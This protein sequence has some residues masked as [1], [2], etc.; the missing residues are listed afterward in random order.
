LHSERLLLRPFV[1]EDV[2]AVFAYA[3]EPTM[4]R[5]TLWETHHSASDSEQFVCEY[6]TSRYQERVPE[7]LAITFRTHPSWVIGSVGCFW[8]DCEQA[9]MELGYVIGMQYWGLGIAVE[10]SRRLLDE[11]FANYPVERVQARVIVENLASIRVCEKLGFTLEGTLR[12]SLF[13]RQ[14]F[15][16]VRYYSLLRHEWTGRR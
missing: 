13:R 6:A 12:H 2:P 9:G 16:D 7:P 10:A 1:P 11:V 8:T 3:R 5:Y 14:Q 4:T 15:W